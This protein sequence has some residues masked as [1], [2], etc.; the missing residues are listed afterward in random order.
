[1]LLG[2]QLTKFRQDVKAKLE[3]DFQY[4]GQRNATQARGT[5]P[6]HIVQCMEVESRI[7]LMLIG[8]GQ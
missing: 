4:G 8:A 1:M 7:Q 2:R 5:W 3:D 6:V